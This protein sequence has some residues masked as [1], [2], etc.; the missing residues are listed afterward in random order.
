MTAFLA[1]RTIGGRAYLATLLP[2]ATADTSAPGMNGSVTISGITSTG[3]HAAWQAATD[4]VA[5][6][7][8]EVSVDTGTPSWIN[9][10]NVTSC[11]VSGKA[12]STAY[13]FRLRAY[14]GAG[15]RA[16][17]ITAPF[18]TSAEASQPSA[19]TVPASRTAKFAGRSRVVVFSGSAPVVALK[20]PLDE[21]YFVG[22]FSKDYLEAGTTAA[23]V[24]GV[25]VG[26]TVLEAAVLQ[27][28]FGAVK[29]GA[30]DLTAAKNL[31]TFRVTLANGEQVDRT[32]EF[33]TLDDPPKVF[34]KDP[35]D[36]RF[37]TFD[38]SSDATFGGSALASVSAPVVVGVSAL[39]QPSM[40]GNAATLKIGGLDTGAAAINSCTLTAVFG[41]TEKIVRSIYFKQEDH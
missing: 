12:A 23:S 16:T 14:D 17:P 22:D 39:S 11:D 4:N 31:F 25:P 1:P 40:Q 38:F 20:G 37:F 27:N 30:L 3:A 9:V 8:Y 26:V 10:G 18:T 6:T 35:D 34:G 41:N 32:I 5:V 7:G 28:G 13:T 21:L 19:V 33:K 36:K 2:P 15:N 29:L 24:V